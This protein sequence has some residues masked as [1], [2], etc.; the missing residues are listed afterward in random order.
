MTCGK[1]EGIPVAV[2]CELCEADEATDGAT[3]ML[4]GI[5]CEVYVSVAVGLTLCGPFPP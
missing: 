4:D 2:Y 3:M 1:L 5:A